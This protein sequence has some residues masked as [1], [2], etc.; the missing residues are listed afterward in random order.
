MSAVPWPHPE[1]SEMCSPQLQGTGNW[2]WLTPEKAKVSC[3]HRM[4]KSVL[5]F[6][7]TEFAAAKLGMYIFP[8]RMKDRELPWGYLACVCAKS[9]QSDMTLCDPVDHSP[10]VSS[11]PGILQERILEWGGGLLCPPPGD[12]PNPGM[13]PTPHTSLALAGRFFTTSGPWAWFLYNKATRRGRK[14]Y[15]KS[16]RWVWI[17]RDWGKRCKW[18]PGKRY[19]CLEYQRGSV[20]QNE[21]L[22]KV[23]KMCSWEK[24]LAIVTSKLREEEAAHPKS[25]L[26]PYLSFLPSLVSPSLAWVR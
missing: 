12:L 4:E 20:P 23:H 15:Q 11:L 9:P 18:T 8:W 24:E 14:K 6:Y 10:P 17:P 16:W 3:G 21:H 1:R 13:E 25:F 7:T 19:T 22:Q 5:G 2:A 26:L